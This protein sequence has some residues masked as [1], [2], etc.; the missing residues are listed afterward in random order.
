M[1]FVC[2][3]QLLLRERLAHRSNS[4]IPTAVMHH[5]KSLVC[6][7][8]RSLPCAFC[9]AHGKKIL[10]RVPQ[11]KRTAKKSTRQNSCFAVC[12]HTAKILPC[13]FFFCTRQTRVLFLA[14]GKIIK[15]IALLTSKLFLPS[16]YNI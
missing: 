9:R 2:S 16:T 14:H 8:F 11:R 10:C 3:I 13:V 15:K 1:N 7:V 6:R 12:W 5:G 4:S